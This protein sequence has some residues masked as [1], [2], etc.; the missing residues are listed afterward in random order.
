MGG[1][2]TQVKYQWDQHQCIATPT[3]QPL[4]NSLMYLTTCNH[5]HRRVQK[6]PDTQDVS[7]NQHT[8]VVLCDDDDVTVPK[9]NSVSRGGGGGLFKVDQFICQYTLP[10][11]LPPFLPPSLPPSLPS[12]H[13]PSLPPFLLSSLPSLLCQGWVERRGYGW[14]R[15]AGGEGGEESMPPFPDTTHF[16]STS[17]RLYFARTLGS[18]F[19]EPN[20]GIPTFCDEGTGALLMGNEYQRTYTSLLEHTH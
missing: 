2:G 14:G 11:S 17:L 6:K 16:P 1:V 15:K 9:S 7:S 12:S 8:I 19:F 13:P 3:E 18:C 20:N 10:S 5:M 4:L